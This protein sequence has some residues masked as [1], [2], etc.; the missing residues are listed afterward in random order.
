MYEVIATPYRYD[1]ICITL[2][3]QPWKVY[4]LNPGKTNQSELYSAQV[5]SQAEAILPFS[6]TVPN[7]PRLVVMKCSESLSAR[8]NFLRLD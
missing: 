3:T 1:H 6:A 8:M 4:L 7:S 2:P 5:A